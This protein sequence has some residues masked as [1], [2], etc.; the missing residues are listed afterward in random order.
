[1]TDP[2]LNRDFDHMGILAEQVKNQ[3]EALVPQGIVAVT[4]SDTVNFAKPIRAFMVTTAGN[5]SV[6]MADGSS[7]IYPS[8]QPGVQYTGKIVRINVTGTATITGIKGFI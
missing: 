5:V 1:M 6:L 2:D 8:C 4:P 7:D 3:K